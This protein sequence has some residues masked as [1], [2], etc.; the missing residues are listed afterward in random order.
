MKHFF[1][2]TELFIAKRLALGDKK[3]FS[4]F[5]IRIAIIAIALSVAVMI[6]SSC[7]VTGF[8]KEIKER[9][10]GF[11]GEIHIANF[12]NN[13]SYESSAIARNEVLVDKIKESKEVKL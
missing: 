8:S 3:S 1:L 4:R 6:I 13:D 5:I 2:N 11:W 9:I 10:F 12:E 7:M